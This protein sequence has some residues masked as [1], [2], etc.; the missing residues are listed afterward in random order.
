MGTSTWS[1]SRISTQAVPQAEQQ[2]ARQQLT[3]KRGI[4]LH[5]GRCCC[6]Q[7]ASQAWLLVRQWMDSVR[8][9]R[10]Q[11][12]PSSGWFSFLE[13]PAVLLV[14]SLALFALPLTGF[15]D[16]FCLASCAVSLAVQVAS[17]LAP[18]CIHCVWG[19]EALGLLWTPKLP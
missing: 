9:S 11:S 16:H 2:P 8:G 15:G 17:P 12:F 18:M 4:A 14:S 6:P 13:G 5:Q 10:S 19:G 1:S 3:R 7:A